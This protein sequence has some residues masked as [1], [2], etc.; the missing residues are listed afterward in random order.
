VL[1]SSTGLIARTS[2]DAP[3]G[4]VARRG[5][6]DT[7]VSVV[8]ATARGQVGVVTS[9]GT[10]HRLEALDLPALP[11]TADS[12]R[13]QGGAPPGALLSLDGDALALMTFDE[14]VPGLALGTRAG[15]VKRVRP[16]HLNRDSWELIRLEDG[17][18]VVGA[19]P[20][21]TGEEELA[22]VTSEAQLLHFSASL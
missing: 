11:P 13:L 18:R 16:D 1:L 4:A 17:D 10:V 9:A 19:V 8:Q 7:V 21:R 3:L 2:D 22:F 12:P 14:D 6:H 5:K 15:V 20:L